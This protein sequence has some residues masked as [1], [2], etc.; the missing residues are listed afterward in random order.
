MVDDR[1]NLSPEDQFILIIEDDPLFA[2]LLME[3]TREK[4]I[5]CIVADN[6]ETGLQLAQQ[7]LPHAII[8]D[9]GLPKMDGWTVM[10]KLKENLDTRHIPVHFITGSGNPVDAKKMGAIGYLHKPAKLGQIDGAI[11][12]IKQFIVKTVKKVLIVVDNDSHQQQIVDS[13]EGNEVQV[14]VAITKT[15][16]LKHLQMAQFDCIILDVDVEQ[17]SGL[18]M[19]EP[20]YNNDQLSK[21]PV[22]AYTD[23]ELSTSE[24]ALLQQCADTLTIKMVKSPERL[25]DQSSLF[26]HQTLAKDKQQKLHHLSEKDSILASKKVLIV[27]DDVRNSFVLTTIFEDKQMEVSVAHSGKEA[28]ALLEQNQDIEIIIMDIMMPEMDGYETMRRIRQQ[29]QFQKLPIIAITAKTMQD[30]K[31]KCFEAGANDYLGK[32]VDTDELMSLMRVWLSQ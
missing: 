27:E 25:L 3:L 26:L 11:D 14:T 10:E 23:R 1:A 16:A 13:V 2:Q 19:L 20:L 9:V 31:D 24:E 8:L 29:P 30:D 5:K 12:D 28:L 32:P 21:M 18:K 4:S 7:Y 17:G 6:G 15:E 22:I